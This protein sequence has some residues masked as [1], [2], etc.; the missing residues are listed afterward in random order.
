LRNGFNEASIKNNVGPQIFRSKTGAVPSIN[1]DYQWNIHKNIGISLYG[2]IGL[3]SFRF[4]FNNSAIAD[5]PFNSFQFSTGSNFQITARILPG[6]D[7]RKS[8]NDKLM[9]N[10]ALRGGIVAIGT[11]HSSWGFQDSTSLTYIYDGNTLKPALIFETGLNY[12][13]PNNDLIGLSVSYEHLLRPIANGYYL[14]G[15]TGSNGTILN[16]GHNIGVSL[17]YTFSQNHNKKR[18]QTLKTEQNLSNKDARKA[19]K[20][21]RRFIDPTTIF[22][23]AGTSVFGLYSSVND[24]NKI[25]ESN[26]SIGGG[27]FAIVEKGIAKDYFLEMSGEAMQF[28]QNLKTNNLTYNFGY[29]LYWTGR[30]S[31]GVGKRFILKKTNRNIFN[32]HSGLSINYTTRE[33]GNNISFSVQSGSS[34]TNYFELIGNEEYKK[35]IFPSFYF[36]LEKDFRLAK[37][38]YFSLKYKF[39]IGLMQVYQLNIETKTAENAL[40]YMRATSKINGTTQG[41]SFGFKFKY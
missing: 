23:G 35:Q 19:Y 12:M 10:T 30:V 2:G 31:F 7:F 39:D 40:E 27:Y 11:T 38:L 16:N 1:F 18:L 15:T 25:Y 17:S 41:L 32:L 36:A 24:P 20:T 4:Q 29:T 13:L 26:W 6:I 9:F 14:D 5:D 3:Y 22:I 21:E 37:M 34:S 28:N 33:P 8:I